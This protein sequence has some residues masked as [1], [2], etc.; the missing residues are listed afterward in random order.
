VP[1]KAGDK[2]TCYDGGAGAEWNIGVIDQY[3]AYQNFSVGSDALTC[4]KEGKYNVY[5]KL[6][7]E[8]DMWYI[9]EYSGDKPGPDY[10]GSVPSKCTDVMFQ[11]FYWDS[12]QDK[13]YGRTK[14]KDLLESGQ[15]VE[16][17]QWFDLVWLPPMSKS[18]GGT[19][20]H[21]I[22]SATWTVRAGARSRI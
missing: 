11:C 13:G 1:L 3:G 4:N 21:P 16:I 14:W 10:S 19:G 20:Y 7:Y 8:D 17:G 15:A 22:C 18:S 6:K 12:Y 5:I 9:E 2:L